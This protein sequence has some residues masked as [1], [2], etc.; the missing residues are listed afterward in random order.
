MSKEYEEI[1][2]K[3]RVI[4]TKA[5]F[6]GRTSNWEVIMDLNDQILTLETS[7]CRLAV[8]KKKGDPIGDRY[9]NNF[10]QEVK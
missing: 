1:K 4:L 8:V 10:V 9:W 6:A 7:T 3:I 5:Y 2:E